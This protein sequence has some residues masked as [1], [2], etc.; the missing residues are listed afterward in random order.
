MGRKVAD[1]VYQIVEPIAQE[2]NL[3][4]VDVEYLKEGNQYI[5][6]VFIDNV[7]GVTLD[8][9]QNISMGLSKILDEKDPIP[10]SY[11]LEVSSPG[12]DRP[13]KKDADFVRFANR[14]IDISTYTR[15]YGKKKKFT[16]EL[17]GL[18]DGKVV[19]EVEGERLEIPRDQISQ[20]RLAVEF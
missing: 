3:E 15:V 7:D 1:I 11:T 14:R 17:I 9:C 2:L 20:I 10:D 8:D 5:L 6:R 13:L 18:V 16:G 19:V 4:L 12:I